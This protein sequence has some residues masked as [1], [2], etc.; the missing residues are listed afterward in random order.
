MTRP[1]PFAIG[2]VRVRVHSGPRKK[3][4]KYRWRADIQDGQRRRNIW[5]GW[6]TED[7]ATQAVIDELAKKG[8]RWVTVEDVRTVF[9]LLDTWVADVQQADRSPH[10]TLARKGCAERMGKSELGGVALQRLDQTAIDRYR[11]TAKNARSTIARDLKALRAAWAWGQSRDLVPQRPLPTTRVEVRNSDRVYNRYT[12]TVAEVA[13]V[14]DHLAASSRPWTARAVR[15]LWATGC[16]PG[17]IARLTWEHVGDGFVTVTGKTGERRVPLHPQVVEEMEA[18]PRLRTVVGIGQQTMLGRLHVHIE[19]AC[20]ALG[21]PRWS[22][23]G[24][25]RAASDALYRSGVDPSSAA[26]TL[27]HSPQTA[28]AH[29]RQVTDAD[30]RGAVLRSGLGALPVEGKVIPFNK[31]GG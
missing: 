15:L 5:T 18:W 23:Y 16:R 19:K 9:D 14:H 11:R 22:P 24:L 2:K 3:D 7:E 25:R 28:M 27:G 4:G 29:Y 12:P 31:E 1:K 13:A 8:E 6:G 20:T 10:T 30:M 21:L 26:A 17:E